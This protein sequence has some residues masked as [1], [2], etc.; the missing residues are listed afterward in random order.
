MSD[1]P[2]KFCKDCANFKEPDLCHIGQKTNVVNGETLPEYIRCELARSVNLWSD[3][4]SCGPEA[5]RF[6]PIDPAKAP[7]HRSFLGF[8]LGHK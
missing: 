2:T 5:K 1:Q 6:T 4:C 7:K 3:N 8:I